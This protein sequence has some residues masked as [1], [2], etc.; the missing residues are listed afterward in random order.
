MGIKTVVRNT[1]AQKRNPMAEKL[2]RSEKPYR[3]DKLVEKWSNVPELGEGITK[4]HTDTA[5][6]LSQLLEN[7]LKYMS[8]LNEAQLSS[9]FYGFTPENMLRI[10]R[11]SYPNSIRGMLFTEFSMES[12]HDSIKYVVPRYSNASRNDF[13]WDNTAYQDGKTWNGTN[14]PMNQKFDDPAHANDVMYESSESRYATELVNVSNIAVD[15]NKVT[16]T[17]AGGA[18]GDDANAFIDGHGTL[19]LVKDGKKIALA[20]QAEDGTWFGGKEIAYAVSAESVTVMKVQNVEQVAA[21]AF[22]FSLQSKTDD[23]DYADADLTGLEFAA[24]GRYDSEKDLTGKYL[25]EVEISMRDY[26]FRPRPIALGVTWTHMA[27]LAL[28]TS[29]GISAEEILMD[30]AAQEIKKT[31]D[32]QSVKQASDSQKVHANDQTVKFNAEAAA[33][34]DDSYYH[35]AQLIGQA[36]ARV[37]HLIYNKIKRGGVSAMVGGPAAVSYLSLNKAWTTRGKQSPVGGY[38][39]GEL[40]GVPVFMVPADI[41][42]DNELLTVWKNPSAEG[43]VAL[44]IGTLIPFYSTGVL[45][46]KF[47]YKEAGIARYEDSQVLNANYFGRIQINGIRELVG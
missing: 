43:D 20:T 10:I 42:P 8:R 5:R 2:Y 9:E 38:K 32:Y 11:L 30:S 36:T 47:F 33:F 13:D 7:Q 34:N 14:W 18:F 3:Q 23:G 12:M 22:K 28:D 19:Y 21:N 37:G 15:G 24:I 46:R 4:M 25:G 45:Q 39:A 35:T 17:Y 16:V 29:F 1:Q 40:D 41:I 27:E 31:L 6:N 44:A 26:H